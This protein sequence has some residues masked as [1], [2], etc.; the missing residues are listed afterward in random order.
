MKKD[1]EISVLNNHTVKQ[2][3]W[4]LSSLINNPRRTAFLQ[5]GS[6]V[7]L[8]EMSETVNICWKKEHSVREAF[9]LKLFICCVRGGW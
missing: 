1:Q 2:S 7:V 6:A 3:E 4:W 5:R 9:L 8:R